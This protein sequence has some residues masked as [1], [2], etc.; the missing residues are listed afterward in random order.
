MINHS[1]VNR[2]L[3]LT[4]TLIFILVVSV[5]ISIITTIPI[6]SMTIISILSITL[7]LSNLKK[8]TNRNL[9]FIYIFI[10]I[11]KICFLLYQVIYKNLPLGGVDWI[12]YDRFGKE[13]LLEKGGNIFEIL[14]LAS[15]ELFTKIT[16][17]IYQI[18]GINAEQLYFYIFIS[19]L[20]V[21]NYINL[22]SNELLKDKIKAQ[23][24]SILFMIWPI[25]FIHSITF[26]RE[27]PIQMLFIISLFHF[28]RVINYKKIKDFIL[29]MVFIIF[30]TL[31][32]SGMI[33][34]LLTYIFIL[35]ASNGRKGIDTL[36]NPFKII[37][38]IV[39]I[40]A[41]LNS[42]LSTSLTTKFGNV[43]SLDSLIE[44]KQ[45]YGDIG[46]DA[47]TNYI[48]SIPENK[49][50]LIMQLPYL[51]TMFSLS[52]FIWQVKNFS[53]LIA[54]FIEGLPRL[55]LVIMLIKYFCSF[56][57]VYPKEK[58]IKITFILI[59]ILTYLI[60]SLG[61]KSYGTAMRHRAKIFPLEIILGYSALTMPKTKI[62][63]KIDSNHNCDLGKE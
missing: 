58:Q 61:T 17:I 56:K 50:E 55:L 40:T 7:I 35:I 4:M 29:A 32:H 6:F 25:E 46:L 48:T 51:V 9:I 44:R 33:G 43:D 1:K 13:L 5:A 22:L 3:V 23:K 20:I 8:V 47:T 60:F 15:D 16:A 24:I 54:F 28:I 19:S 31:M 37:L 36:N 14:F 38:F 21:F 52:P 12:H 41:L 10:I 53:T 45:Q 27:M 42:P 62:K 2:V 39:I 59:I 63:Y 11:I 34:I 49:K 26:L 18:F 30:A 57:P